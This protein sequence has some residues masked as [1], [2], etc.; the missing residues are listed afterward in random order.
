MLKIEGNCFFDIN[1]TF[2][3]SPKDGL[4]ISSMHD[5]P[6]N[7]ERKGGITLYWQIYTIK[8]NFG[9]NTTIFG[10]SR[11]VVKRLSNQILRFFGPTVN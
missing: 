10:K 3:P 8:A 7:F 6:S 11:Q 5:D 1:I 4:L 9:L 2:I